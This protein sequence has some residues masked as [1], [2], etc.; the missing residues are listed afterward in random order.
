MSQ[1][2]THTDSL[3]TSSDES[4]G[5]RIEQPQRCVSSENQEWVP[6]I[7]LSKER[8]DIHAVF[9]PE[10]ALDIEAEAARLK[11]IMDE[12]GRAHV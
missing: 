8:W 5:Q 7:G 12:I 2:K 11:K 9:L 6:S 4:C 10:M 3:R 1:A